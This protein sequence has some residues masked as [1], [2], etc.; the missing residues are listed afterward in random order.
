[1]QFRSHFVA[2]ALAFQI[3]RPVDQSVLESGA[4]KVV[5]KGS[6]SAK[7]LVDGKPVAAS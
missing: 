3:L 4:V 6:E 5:A 2:A 1:M 7:L